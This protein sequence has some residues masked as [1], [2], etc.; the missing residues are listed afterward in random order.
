MTKH[1]LRPYQEHALNEIRSHFARGN[2]RV[3]LHLA[4]G[5]G[6]TTL[7]SAVLKGVHAKGHHGIMVVRGKD[8]V[9]QASQRLF[10]EGVPHGVM[11]GGHWNKNANALIQVC[12]ID[13]LHRRKVVP[14]ARIVVIDEAHF[15]CSP[16]FKW[17]V[18][19][20][21]DAYFLP[22]TAT[23]YVK[24]GLRHVADHVVFPIAIKD[25][26]TQGYLSKPRYFAPPSD[27]DLSSVRTDKKTGDY[28]LTDLA[29]AVDKAHVTGD[30]IEHYKSL[31][32]G[33][34][35]VLFAVS[36]AHSKEIVASLIAADIPAEHMEA[37]TPQSERKAILA[38]LESGQTKIVSNVGILCTG[39]DL[40][41]LGAVI[42]A[43]PTKSKNLHIQQ[44]GRG[45]R[46]YPGKSDFLVLDHAR[47]IEAHGFIET[48][49]RCNLDGVVATKKQ[50]IVTCKVC[51]YAW[52][53]S[54]VDTGYICQGV[55]TDGT[56]CE[57]DNTPKRS[58]SSACGKTGDIVTDRSVSLKEITSQVDPVRSFVDKMVARAVARNYKSGWIFHKV[59]D[60]FGEHTAQAF[61]PIIKARRS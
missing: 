23:P 19:Q 20:Y 30:I 53:P 41:Y 59:K 29:Q 11:Q 36:I 46:V 60:K 15:A 4:T 8:L 3:L 55:L 27:L 21:P 25:L 40:P 54:E 12:S 18:D 33:R 47:N 58:E 5:A 22:V 2:K 24:E 10:R 43:R 42:M 6:K 16:S 57:H 13:T 32:M 56:L 50:K 7:F 1:I 44:I 26:M 14:P 49:D 39:I 9:D 28:H 48:E 61:W 34:P 31:A 35:A 51:Y 52:D 38:R 17:L 45:T 37:D